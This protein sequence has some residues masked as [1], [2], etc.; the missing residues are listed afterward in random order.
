MRS[1]S[2]RILNSR[3]DLYLGQSTQT[4]GGFKQVYPA[5]PTTSQVPCAISLQGSETVFDQDRLTIVNTYRLL[6]AGPTGLSARDQVIWVDPI[7]G[8]THT[9]FVLGVPPSGAN[10]QASYALMA[11]ERL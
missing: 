5:S 8:I 7:A 9:L 3:V 1:P 10:R 6:F 2:S 4:D 11:E